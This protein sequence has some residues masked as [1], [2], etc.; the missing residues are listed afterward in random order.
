MCEIMAPLEEVPEAEEV[1]IDE[2]EIDDNIEPVK[3]AR[4][5]KLPSKQGVESHRCTHIPFRLW[6]KWCMMGRGRGAQH[7]SAQES[8]VPMVGI[9]YFFI[10]H[11][12]VQKRNE[13]EH[14]ETEEGEAALNGARKIGDLIKCI[15]VRCFATKCLA[16]HCVPYKGAGEDD[17]VA[18][19][20]AEDILWLGHSELIVKSDN[21]PAL[22]ALITRILEVVGSR[23]AS[24]SASAEKNPPHTTLSRTA[25]RRSA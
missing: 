3:I 23:A 7:R 10:S 15:L 20:V 24:R 12:G 21:E 17:Y 14:P 8:V 22:Q 18:G 4:D 13:V 11:G 9:D 6:C 25:L 16:A 1:T 2:A 5:P 19:L